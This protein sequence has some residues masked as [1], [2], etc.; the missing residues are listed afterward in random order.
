MTFLEPLYLAA[1][2]LAALPIIIHLVHLWR[3]KPIPWAA[4]MFLHLAQQ[5]NR[6]LSRLRQILILA[7]RVLAVACVLLSITRPLAGGWLG[8]TGGAPETILV[9]LDRSASMEQHPTALPSSKR[10]A[11]LQ[12]VAK[13]IRQSSG[14][15]SKVV[16]LDSA[17]LQPLLLSKPE[18]LLDVPPA[19][20][21]D[22]QADLPALLQSALDY[23]SLHQSGRTDLWILSDLQKSDWDRSSGRWQNLRAAF[24][25]LPGVRFHLLTLPQPPEDDLGIRLENVSRK[26]AGDHAE[27]QFDLFL[28][29]RSAVS[30][31]QEVPLR[32][33]LNGVATTSKVTL[34]D[35]Q[36]V[37]HAFSLPLDRSLLR[38]WGRVEL[39]ADSN[40]SNNVFHFVFEPPPPL[41][42]VLVSEE[43]SEV[44]PLQAALSSPLE[45]GRDFLSSPLPLARAHEIPW[46]DT[47]LLVWHAPLPKP[48]SPLHRQ[49]LDHV[50]AGRTL[51][52]LPP[53]TPDD[54]DLLGL[55]W[56]RWETM[57]Q[58]VSPDWWKNDSDLLANTRDG[59]ALPVGTLEIQRLCGVAGNSLPLALLP[60]RL[61]LLL[62]PG[63][64]RNAFFLA[65]L[66]S[67]GASSLARDG[68]VLFA[69]LH[70]A[71][72]EG[73]Q[74]LGQARHRPAAANALPPPAA[75]AAPWK[76]VDGRE[77]LGIPAE[78]LP[79]HAG[80]LQSGQ[81]LLAL[82][83]PPGEDL[84]EYLAP[85]TLHELFA[86][87]DARVLTDSLEDTRDLTS[88]VW[89]TF[90]FAMALALLAEA[91]L[92][93]PAPPSTQRNDSP[94]H[95]AGF[96]S[97]PAP[98]SR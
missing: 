70:R 23:L 46:E 94:S 15:H 19:G 73:A 48:D 79:L 29:R 31:P 58:P 77:S 3:R 60:G 13:A 11:A 92:C 44:L 36:L 9:L 72:A 59:S 47:A 87:L 35:S 32:F 71:L 25:S 52:L 49:L 76:P 56:T 55:R 88:E 68:V 10:E 54:S 91:V 2:P 95:A 8:L 26:A 12:K 82:N 5:R 80:I 40:P 84:P 63:T 93:L 62:R 24:T 89:R 57:P 27:L 28:T 65:T 37:L 66:P 4:M 50:A 75:E 41:R 30:S 53:Q 33:I 16:L 97:A 39:P 51:L 98:L 67:P 90:L 83:R 6:G 42:S 78:Q 74:T 14:D 81:K 17:S 69:L 34:K 64:E 61:P 1:L 86:G 85:D 7:L 96:A 22:T 18:A 45:P 21:S 20:S 43:P 38:G